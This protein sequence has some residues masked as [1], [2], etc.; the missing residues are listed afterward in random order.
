MGIHEFYKSFRLA[1][2][3]ATMK[4]SAMEL[5]QPGSVQSIVSKHPVSYVV[6][7][8]EQNRKRASP[9]FVALQTTVGLPI[10]VSYLP[11]VDRRRRRDAEEAAG[12]KTERARCV[13]R[14]EK[15]EPERKKQMVH[16]KQNTYKYQLNYRTVI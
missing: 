14:S 11:E 2:I 7:A 15:R 3:S 10:F 9:S 16:T 4:A 6:F 13:R 8:R 12:N 1:N 5:S